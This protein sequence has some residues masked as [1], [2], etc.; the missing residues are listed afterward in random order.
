MEK[1]INYLELKSIYFIL[2]AIFIVSFFESLALTGLFL[3]G[4]ILMIGLGTF[5][6]N[7]KVSLYDA[8]FVGIIGCLLG[9]WISYFIGLKL[10]KKYI[11]KI[12]FLNITSIIDK[13]EYTLNHY[14]VIT[15]FIGK[16]IGPI[17]PLIPI[18]SGILKVPLKKF[19][20]PNL[21]GCVLWPLLYFIPG[22]LAKSVS[23]IP[24]GDKG[25]FKLLFFFLI[26]LI[27][28]E[29]FLFWKLFNNSKYNW[30]NKILS[31]RNIMILILTFLIFIII[32]II[33]LQLNSQTTVLKKLLIEIFENFN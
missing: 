21:F 24:D 20:Y 5:I 30:I 25:N 13:I 6:G 1:F 23:N 7:H 33:F 22:I 3:P 17:R 32:N 14:S 9:D 29:F 27:W 15:I 19:F 16:F 31:K 18:L 2:I 12:N 10:K 11:K 4:T 28:C 26:F 8:W